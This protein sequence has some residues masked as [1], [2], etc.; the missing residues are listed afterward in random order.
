MLT[1]ELY[2]VTTSTVLDTK[3]VA[4]IAAYQAFTSNTVSAT[5]V[6]GHTLEIRLTALAGTGVNSG[7]AVAQDNISVSVAPALTANSS[8]FSFL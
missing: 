3:T 2:D 8:F 6:V 5:C 1:V 4:N 7:Y